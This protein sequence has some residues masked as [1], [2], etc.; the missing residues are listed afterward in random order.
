MNTIYGKGTPEAPY[1]PIATLNGGGGGGTPYELPQAGTN[2]LGGVKAN[3]VQQNGAATIDVLQNNGLLTLKAAGAGAAGGG[4]ATNFGAV[5]GAALESGQTYVN[6]AVI[7]GEVK[8]YTPIATQ[9]TLGGVKASPK[10]S[11]MTQAVG[12]DSVGK[13]WVKEGGS[14]VGGFPWLY[15]DSLRLFV[16]DNIISIIP[17]TAKDCPPTAWTILGP[18][19]EP[20]LT[21]LK[22]KFNHIIGVNSYMGSI[23]NGPYVPYALKIETIGPVTRISLYNYGNTQIT[24]SVAR[25]LI[26]FRFL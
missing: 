7:N 8:T 22:A 12:I 19:N 17:M 21:Q 16:S 26:A 6:A 13:L 3:T 5:K 24:L 15:L 4:S 14:A 1:T 18:I 20:E 11:D 9:N 2:I 10:S 23:Q 25:Q